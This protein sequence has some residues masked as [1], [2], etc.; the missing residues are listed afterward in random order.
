ML[1][2]KKHLIEKIVSHSF[3]Q[4]KTK[5]RRQ[6]LKLLFIILMRLKPLLGFISKRLGKE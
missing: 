2:G 6:P 4:M 5:F 1:D 3:Y